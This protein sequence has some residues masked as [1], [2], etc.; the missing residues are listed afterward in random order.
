MNQIWKELC[1]TLRPE[2][3]AN[4]QMR[5]VINGKI[6]EDPGV[7]AEAFVDFFKKKVD[8]LV[9]AVK[10]DPNFDP[11]EPLREKYENSDLKFSFKP[12]D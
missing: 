11:L 4:N 8:D 7:I 5:L 1:I 10:S 3:F 2:R 12:V 9:I 6:T